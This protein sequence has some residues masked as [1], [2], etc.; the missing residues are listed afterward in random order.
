MNQNLQEEA[1]GGQQSE[2]VSLINELEASP[3]PSWENITYKHN[4]MYYK[5]K[6]SKLSKLNKELL[7][8]ISDL[9]GKQHSPD[10][11]LYIF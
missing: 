2:D 8:E 6:A 5:E 3:D 9:K 1:K 11:P 4:I 10:H 7:K